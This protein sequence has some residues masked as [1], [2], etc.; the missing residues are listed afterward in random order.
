MLAPVPLWPVTPRVG[1][2]TDIQRGTN[3]M[4]RVAAADRRRAQDAI[5]AAR[6]YAQQLDRVLRELH[7]SVDTD[8]QPLFKERPGNR[9]SLVVVTSDRGLCGAFTSGV[10][11]LVPAGW[12]AVGGS[13]AAL[14]QA[15][16]TGRGPLID[17]A[18][19]TT[20]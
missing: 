17:R 11:R 16:P 18:P 14:L 9:V 20:F 6:P 7:Q 3:A 13:T 1:S 10:W 15:R 19:S 4:Q 5:E 8:E 12:G 2:M